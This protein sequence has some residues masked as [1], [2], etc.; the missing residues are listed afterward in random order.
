M[1]GNST[2]LNYS[3]LTPDPGS[4][5]FTINAFGTDHLNADYISAVEGSVN[6][7][8][9]SNLVVTGNMTFGY[10]GHLIG[11]GTITNNGDISIADGDISA[12]VKGHGTLELHNYHDGTGSQVISGAIGAGQTVWLVDH[13]HETHTELVNPNTFK[14]ALE[15]AN[16]ATRDGRPATLMVDG[17]HAS[18]MDIRGDVLQLQGVR[19]PPLWSVREHMPAGYTASMLDTAAGTQITF[20]LHQ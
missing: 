7:A 4:A 5:K 14:A 18:S 17:I 3:G 1:R 6:I 13:Q 19:G 8:A 20:A 2:L 10:A 12:N 11:P 9:H 15:V 16:I